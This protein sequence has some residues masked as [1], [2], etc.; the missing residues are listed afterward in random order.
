MGAGLD[1]CWKRTVVVDPAP[2][3]RPWIVPLMLRP[4]VVNPLMVRLF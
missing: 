3:G 2:A 4:L 1:P